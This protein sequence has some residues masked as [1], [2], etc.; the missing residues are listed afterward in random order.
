[1]TADLLLAPPAP[2]ADAVAVQ[3]RHAACLRR[4]CDECREVFDECETEFHE[5]SEMW[6]CLDC[7][8]AVELW[9]QERKDR[10]DYCY[11]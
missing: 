11:R 6:L 5:P 3:T 9:A 4:E 2:S 1:M 10:R 7:V 8:A